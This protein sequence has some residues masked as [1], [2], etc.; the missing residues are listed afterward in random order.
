MPVV[1][2]VYPQGATRGGPL[3][4]EILGE[5]LDRAARLHFLGDGIAARI[6]DGGYSRL[7]VELTVSAAASFGPHYFRVITPRGA[8]NLMLF[9]VGDQPHLSEQEPNTTLDEAQ[10]IAVPA[11]INGRLN[12]D[13]D[14]DF[15]RFRAR[16]NET[17][18]FDLRAARNGNGLDAALILADEHGRRLEHREDVFIWDPFFAHTF[19]ADG[20]YAVIVQP[21]HVR[22]DPNF[23]YQLDIRRSPHLET[24]APLALRPGT[25][26]EATVYGAALAGNGKLWASGAG[27]AGEV[28]EMRGT[29]ARVRFQLAPDARSGPREFAIITEHGRSNTATLLVDDTPAHS[30][31]AH[32]HPP[33]AVNSVARYREPE[34][35][36]FDAA[37]GQTL[38]FETRAQRFGSPADTKLRVLDASGQ[39]VAMNDD[40]AFPGAQFNKDSLLVHTFKE[41][42]RYLLEIRNLYKTT[43]EHYPYHLVVRPPQPRYELIYDT[44]N[45]WI[46]A[47]AEGTLKLTIARRDGFQGPVKPALPDPPEGIEAK[48][49]DGRISFRAASLPPATAA[50]IHVPGAFRSVRIASGGGEGATFAH[51]ASATLAVIEKP[52]FALEAAVSTVNLVRGG[53]V[54][55]AVNITRA[56]GFAEP[57]TFWF[58]NLPE[59]VTAEETTAS[60]SR[61]AVRLRAAADARTGRSA[62]VIILGKAAGGQV[63]A[64]PKISLVVD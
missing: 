40:G 39:E 46:I 41:A 36:T 5:Q 3:R 21:T 17:W 31:G 44:D 35:F 57:V 16:R 1:S 61:A 23:A 43:G 13:G 59:G 37:A 64:A 24:V 18:V 32:L 51:V 11:T 28:L 7:D 63:Q 26:T 9:R 4:V 56:E 42:G 50:E 47:G 38:V 29:T 55:F 25:T 45:P 19:E 48:V 8:S 27:I 2:S 34:R 15:F 62:R 60:G 33:A 12:R 14:F 6:L 49:G 22:L 20:E 53:A 54:E 30:G 52:L 10:E 58:E